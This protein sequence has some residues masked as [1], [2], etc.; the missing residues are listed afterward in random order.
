MFRRRYFAR[1]SVG[2]RP[3]CLLL[4]VLGQDRGD[5]ATMALMADAPAAVGVV[6]S[7]GNG[8]GPRSTHDTGQPNRR[9]QGIEELVVMSLASA[10][11]HVQSVA[12]AITEEV[13]LA[14]PAPTR[15][16]KTEVPPFGAPPAA[17]C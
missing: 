2:F 1:S 9:Q 15:P 3:V 7:Q 14:G 5:V 17:E 13:E 16:A 8:L 4:F 11:N 6:P 12:T 10:D